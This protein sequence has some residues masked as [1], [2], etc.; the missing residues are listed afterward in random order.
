MSFTVALA[1]ARKW[2]F[3]R[4]KLTVRW[5]V[6]AP[7]SYSRWTTEGAVENVGKSPRDGFEIRRG[8]ISHRPDQGYASKRIRFPS[9]DAAAS[10]AVPRPDGA[11]RGD[12]R[13]LVDVTIVANSLVGGTLSAS[14]IRPTTK[15][16]V[17]GRRGQA[18]ESRFPGRFECSSAVTST[19]NGS[20]KTKPSMAR[21]PTPNGVSAKFWARWTAVWS[22]PLSATS[23]ANGYNCG[24]T[25]SSPQTRNKNL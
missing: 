23:S 21:R 8:R 2:C 13:R 16:A 25:K 12:G 9:F 19:A 6:A 10:R 4:R 1:R 24:W 15:E 22:H 17:H 18:A 7:S 20:E 5:H 11:D 14:P 3:F